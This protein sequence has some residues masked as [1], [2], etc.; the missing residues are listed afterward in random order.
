[1]CFLRLLCDG[2]KYKHK[3]GAEFHKA[4]IVGEKSLLHQQFSILWISHS[5]LNL[6]GSGFAR[7]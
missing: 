2:M 6:Q 5:V 4:I 1:L 3:G 7:F